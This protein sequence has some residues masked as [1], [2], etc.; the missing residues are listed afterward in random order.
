ME[1]TKYSNANSQSYG[2]WLETPDNVS[3]I[4]I[5]RINGNSRR[6]SASNADNA[7]GLGTRPAIEVQKSNIS[8]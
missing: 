5:L 2:G 3:S 7:V 8:Y 6:V 4:Y 1:N